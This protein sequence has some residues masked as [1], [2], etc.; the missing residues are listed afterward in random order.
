[1]G[2]FAG[3]SVPSLSVKNWRSAAGRA[4]PGFIEPDRETRSG[5]VLVA[6][7]E[8]KTGVTATPSHACARGAAGAQ[9]HVEHARRHDGESSDWACWCGGHDVA[10]VILFRC[11][12][13]VAAQI[14]CGSLRPASAHSAVTG[15][16]AHRASAGRVS[17]PRSRKNAATPTP[18]QAADAHHD[19]RR[20][21]IPATWA[22]PTCPPSTTRRSAWRGVTTAGTAARAGVR[23]GFRFVSHA[24]VCQEQ[25]GNPCTPLRARG[26]APSSVTPCQNMP[27]R[28]RLR[29]LA[30]PRRFSS[31]VTSW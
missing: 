21:A 22:R 10:S 30:A 17:P 20:P 26:H 12:G 11:C 4:E 7:R 31:A 6:F 5:G 19:G 8:W 9:R 29:L 3:W 14:P 27:P 1:M 25:Y 16:R 15:Q 2:R 24:G 28:D 13:V 23:G 18:R